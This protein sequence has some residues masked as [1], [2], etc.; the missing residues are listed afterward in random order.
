MFFLFLRICT[1]IPFNYSALLLLFTT[2][3]SDTLSSYTK[4]HRLIS[5]SLVLE[6]SIF[7]IGILAHTVCS[8]ES[9]NSSHS[10]SFSP[11]LW[12]FLSL[13]TLISIGALHSSKLRLLPLSTLDWQNFVLI[14]F[15]QVT[16]SFGTWLS[17]IF[18]SSE[19]LFSTEVSLDLLSTFDT[20]AGIS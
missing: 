5:V 2:L 17:Q 16:A 15:G 18:T 14:L 3:G 1:R 13:E 10:K 9:T 7:D 19:I 11:K 4:R 8:T 20:G 12:I 6:S